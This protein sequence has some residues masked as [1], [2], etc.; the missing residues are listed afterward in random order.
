MRETRQDFFGTIVRDIR[1]P[2]GDFLTREDFIGIDIK[3]AYAV[4]CKVLE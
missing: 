2:P 4:I 1:G 3:G